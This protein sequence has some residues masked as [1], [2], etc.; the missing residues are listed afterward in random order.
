[1]R[2]TETEGVHDMNQVK[3]DGHQR[4][5]VASKSLPLPILSKRLRESNQD[6]TS[7]RPKTG[8]KYPG[9]QRDPHRGNPI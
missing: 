7:G 2:K 8:E 5:K 1:M 9:F 3:D 6:H 4:K